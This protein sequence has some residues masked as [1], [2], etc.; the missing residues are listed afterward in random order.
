LLVLNIALILAFA[1]AAIGFILGFV[2]FSEISETVEATV[3]KDFPQ[4]CCPTPIPPDAQFGNSATGS[5]TG[6]SEGIYGLRGFLGL[7]VGEEITGLRA[8]VTATTG[9]QTRLIVYNSTN[10]LIGF[11]N[12]VPASPAG[13]K[14]YNFAVNPTVP[15]DGFVYIVHNREPNGNQVR[16]RTGTGAVGFPMVRHLANDFASPSLILFNNA[17][18]ST[19]TH[20]FAEIF[21]S[22]ASFQQPFTQQDVER[23]EGIQ[24]AKSTGFTVLAILPISLFFIIFTVVGNFTSRT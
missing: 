3:L 6:L 21:V 16:W 15:D 18:G 17:T 24:F 9:A 19:N 12:T 11:T 7:T 10:D 1:G 8:E 14:D 23:A 5:D 22:Q 13:L 4:G 20:V 2:I